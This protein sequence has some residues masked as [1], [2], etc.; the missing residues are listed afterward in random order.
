MGGI[1]RLPSKFDSSRGWIEAERLSE[2]D[3]EFRFKETVEVGSVRSC[4]RWPPRE[5]T[6]SVKVMG[7]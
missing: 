1:L 7:K 3:G 6:H 2:N 4:Q 5:R